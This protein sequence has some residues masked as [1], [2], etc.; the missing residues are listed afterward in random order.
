MVKTEN[1]K[2]KKNTAVIYIV[3]SVVL[4]INRF[5]VNSSFISFTILCSISSSCASLDVTLPTPLRTV[6]IVFIICKVFH[7][8]SCIYDLNLPSTW[9]RSGA[10]GCGSRRSWSRC[11]CL[12]PHKYSAY[13]VLVDYHTN[14]LFIIVINLITLVFVQPQ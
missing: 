1:K 3:C 4:K 14:F 5:S 7:F 9:R 12:P 10:A 6:A 2:K 8:F 13:S 11:R